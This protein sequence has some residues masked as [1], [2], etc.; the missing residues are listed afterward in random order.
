[1]QELKDLVRRL[2]VHAP[3]Q[4]LCMGKD[5]AGDLKAHPWFNGFDWEAFQQQKL[6]APHI[7]K[8]AHQMLTRGAEPTFG[9]PAAWHAPHMPLNSTFSPASFSSALAA[10]VAED[11]SCDVQIAHPEDTRNF[12]A[13]PEEHPAGR[14]RRGYQSQGIFKDF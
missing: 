1:M 11:L 12:V 10:A 7:P 9:K 4:R 3:A 13:A 6:P 5:G 2:L 14:A 8:V